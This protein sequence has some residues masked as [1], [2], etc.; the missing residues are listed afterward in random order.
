VTR[1]PSSLILIRIASRF[2]FHSK[3]SR[4]ALDHGAGAAVAVD[5]TITGFEGQISG[6]GFDR[7]PK[8]SPAFCLIHC[9][10]A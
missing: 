5:H 8:K 6:D 9:G 2:V 1:Y 3:L 4:Q 10:K 7:A